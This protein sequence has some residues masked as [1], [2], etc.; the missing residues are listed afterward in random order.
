MDWF[1]GDWH[2]GHANIIKYCNRPFKDAEHM[3]NI[4]IDNINECAVYGDRIFNVGDV[5]L[6]SINWQK[7]KDRLA[8]KEIH[9]IPGNHDNDK[10][11]QRY[12]HILPQIYMYKKDDFRMVLSHYALRVWP[13]GHH[14][15]GHLYGHSHG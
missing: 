7:L 9:V 14:G 8:C 3:D 2:F 10:I 13:H 1:T 5:A 12:F 4:L 15:V 11:L 6:K